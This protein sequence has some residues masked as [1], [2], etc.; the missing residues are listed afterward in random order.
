[1]DLGRLDTLARSFATAGSRRSLVRLV[2]AVPVVGGMLATLTPEEM[3][4]KDR[5]RRRKQR[6]KRRKNPGKGKRTCN[7]RSRDRT[8]AGKCGLVRNNC[9]KTVD[10]GS[11]DCSLNPAACP[12]GTCCAGDG[13]CQV[14]TTNAACGSGGACDVCTGQEECQGQ[15]CVCVPDC[16]RKCGGVDDGCGGSCSEP[17]P[18]GR[19]CLSNGSCAVPCPGGGDECSAAGCVNR[20]IVTDEG[21]VCGVGG[22]SDSC[23][24]TAQCPAGTACIGPV[25]CE[26]LC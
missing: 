15:T 10:C 14:G 13:A 11:C 2:A 22:L 6:H 3:A 1:M 16:D 18:G 20:C 17:C 26:N 25:F 23:S 4:A 24:T 5:R 19:V 9:K 12:N 21:N 8:C 7:P